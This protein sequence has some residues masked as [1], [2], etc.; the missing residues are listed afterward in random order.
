MKVKI[1]PYVNHISLHKIVD[2]L[3]RLNFS[4]EQCDKITEWLEK[5]WVKNL[6]DWTNKRRSRTIKIKID[7]F[8]TWNMDS[9]LAYIIHPMLVQLK[10]ESNSYGNVDLEDIPLDARSNDIYLPNSGG[11]SKDHW[12]WV[13]DEMIWAFEQKINE[14]GD[15]QF[16]DHSEVDP[17]SSLQSQIQSIKVD[18]KGLKEYNQRMA[19]GFRLFGKYYNS[20]WD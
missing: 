13:L 8:D 11:Y 15:S 3:E 9:T 18:H 6:I 4:E 20:L 16:F 14:T 19:N 2:R 10:T 12:D 7:K 5:T 17:N 1:G